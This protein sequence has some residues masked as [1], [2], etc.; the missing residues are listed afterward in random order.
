[1]FSQTFTDWAEGRYVTLVIPGSRRI[2]T[3]C[4]VEIYGYRSPT[5]ENL[6]YNMN[7]NGSNNCHLIYE[8]W[9][10]PK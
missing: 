7:V 9:Y 6:S 1:M 10:K 8:M 5:G 4:E 3:V 2:I